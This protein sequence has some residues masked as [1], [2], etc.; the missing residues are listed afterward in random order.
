MKKNKQIRQT[1][2][3]VLAAVIAAVSTIAI[4]ICGFFTI[5]FGVGEEFG[6]QPK[7]L[8]DAI[9]RRLLQGYT[10]ELYQGSGLSESWSAEKQE[11]PVWDLLDGGNIRY[12]VVKEKKTVYSN[13][14]SVDKDHCLYSEELNPRMDI[15]GCG[16]DDFW[17]VLVSRH[18]RENEPDSDMAYIVSIVYDRQSGL[19]YWKSNVHDYFPVSQIQFI[20][21]YTNYEGDYYFLKEE[22]G[23]TCYVSSEDRILSKDTV[24]NQWAKEEGFLQVDGNLGAGFSDQPN[25][26]A[27][28]IRMVDAVPEDQVIWTEWTDSQITEVGSDEGKET[29][30]LLHYREMDPAPQNCY[31]VYMDV[32]DPVQEN[33]TLKNGMGDYFPQAEAL[34]SYLIYF[35]HTSGW[36]LALAVVIFLAAFVY[37]MQ[38]AGRRQADDEIHLR[39]ADKIP[40]GVLTAAV[41]AI[42]AGC[43]LLCCLVAGVL[44]NGEISFSLSCGLVLLVMAVCA[45]TMLEF[46]MSIAVRVKTKNFWRYTIL[47]YLWAPFRWGIEMLKAKTPLLLKAIAVFAAVT[48]VEAVGVASCLYDGDTM[49]A[50]FFFFK[51]IEFGLLLWIV[52]QLYRIR[53]GGRR[54]AAGDYSHPIDTSHMLGEL[55]KHAENINNVGTGISQAVNAKIKSERF[56]TELITNVSHDIKTPLTS[57]INYVDLMKKEEIGNPKVQEYIGIL[58]HQ[59][60]RLKKLIEDLME[61]SKASTGNLPV[62]LEVC[63]ATVMLTQVVGEFEDRATAKQLEFV[64]ESPDPPVNIMADGRHLWRI[65]DNLMSNI[66]K[67]AMPGT[68]V[69]IS[70]EQ[71][72]GMVIMT[73]RNISQSR[74]N[75][76]SD[77]LME[78]FVR[79]DSSRNTE[80]NGLGLSIAQSLTSLMDGNLA[81][82]IDGDLFK[83]ILSFEECK[84]RS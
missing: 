70:L 15:Y 33:L 69:Y 76:S 30:V 26:C 66:C 40:F 32:A 49:A 45:F 5:L 60:A 16:R 18:L 41:T 2:A 83:V 44:E 50:G 55:K 73:F 8:E 14:T 65:I 63:D 77:E 1:W 56:K 3:K 58:D 59:S 38:A 20:D 47:H 22:E 9:N 34:S 27:L 84:N 6:K 42:S 10:A 29:E 78:R 57:I 28:Q 7:A 75:I 46:A 21:H 43:V 39:F 23:K 11:A 4:L 67:Y 64:V 19:F 72:H 68:R 25:D 53:E 35:R 81:I 48:I 37:L 24:E 52:H 82:Q 79:G 36:Y 54:I 71:F 74:L 61:A 13:D 12:T 80:G 62:H 51:C 31:Q 17:N